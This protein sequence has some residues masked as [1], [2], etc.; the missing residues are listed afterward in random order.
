MRKL[1]FFLMLTLALSFVFASQVLGQN[2]T[3]PDVADL[4]PENLFTSTVD[5]LYGL[6]IVLSG[7]LSAFIP[8]IN[9]WKPFFRVIAFALATGVGIY[10][11][12]GASVWKLAFTYFVSTGLYEVFI[13]HIFKSPQ[14]A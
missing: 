14:P 11:F 8:G 13:K 9:R 7:Y 4:T 6:V 5:P 3:F 1:G 10:L 2:V 12:G